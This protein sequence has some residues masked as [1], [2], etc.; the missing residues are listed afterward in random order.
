MATHIV[1]CGLDHLGEV[2]IVRGE[3]YALGCPDGKQLIA[4]GNSQRL[5][6][7]LVRMT[8]KE[9]PTLRTLTRAA[10]ELTS[11]CGSVIT[12]VILLCKTA[13]VS[14]GTSASSAPHAIWGHRTVSPVW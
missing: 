7:S 13:A 12:S 9:L 1:A 10:I 8:P 14:G 2:R 4:L 3:T 5:D 6:T 11:R